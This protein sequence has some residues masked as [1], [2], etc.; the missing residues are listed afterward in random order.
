[1]GSSIHSCYTFP[2]RSALQ[3]Q[4]TWLGCPSDAKLTYRFQ[5]RD[6]R[7]PGV[8]GSLFEKLPV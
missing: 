6:C 5:G 3:K 7:L 8:G 4:R 2:S 1:M